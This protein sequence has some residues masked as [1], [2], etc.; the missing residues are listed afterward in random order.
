[1]IKKNKI[2]KNRCLKDVKLI[3]WKLQNIVERN[4]RKPK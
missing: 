3:F 2:L 4:E 1:M